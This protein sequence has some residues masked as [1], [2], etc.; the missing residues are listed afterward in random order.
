MRAI[1]DND[2][3]LKGACYGFLQ[4]LMSAVPGD[5]PV[6]VLGSSQFIV[7][8]K[9]IKMRLNRPT[10]QPLGEFASFLATCHVIEPSEAEQVM[11]AKL[12]AAA[13][14]MA[15]NLD[16]G[17][18]QLIAVTVSRYVSWLVTGDKRA[19]VSVEPLLKEQ[20]ELSFLAGK[21]RC[22]EQLVMALMLSTSV[23]TL[24]AAICAEARVDR[25]LNIC[26]ACNSAGADKAV[27]IAGLES[28]IGDLRRAA[29]L[30]LAI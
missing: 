6:G 19:I 22:F 18:S 30:V 9:I 10:D 28:Y 20:A 24:R 26:F 15:L 16:T 23:A 12:E 17:E 11:A 5:G 21:I 14:M 3:L 2:V 7:P 1:S 13:Q 25:A 27:V 29:P 8:K 4:A